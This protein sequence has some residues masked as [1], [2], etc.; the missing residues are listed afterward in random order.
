MHI[1]VTCRPCEKRLKTLE[2]GPGGKPVPTCR[3]ITVPVRSGMPAVC[4]QERVLH[5][6]L[7]FLAWERQTHTRRAKQADR[8]SQAHEASCGKFV[9]GSSQEARLGQVARASERGS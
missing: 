8:E 5:K 4:A 3:V 1:L 2:A 7:S 9:D 6:H